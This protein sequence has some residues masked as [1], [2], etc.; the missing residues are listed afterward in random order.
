MKNKQDE[1]ISVEAGR[2][3]RIERK[4]DEIEHS[5]VSMEKAVVELT[6]ISKGNQ[7]LLTKIVNDIE[8]RVY[9][10]EKESAV[11]QKAVDDQE[12]MKD[13]IQHLRTNQVKILT[14]CSVIIFIISVFGPNI[15]SFFFG[16]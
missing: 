10:L 9:Q 15:N 16:G 11:R 4:V 13:D 3:D 8:P 6:I 2:V 12:K 14:V 1:L 7:E 5:Q